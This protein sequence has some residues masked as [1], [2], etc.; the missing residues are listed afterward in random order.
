MSSSIELRRHLTDAEFKRRVLKSESWAA[1]C[2]LLPIPPFDEAGAF[3]EVTQRNAIRADSQLPLVDSAEEVGRLKAHYEGSTFADRIR[4][5]TNECVLEIYG[6]EMLKGLSG[7][8]SM[9]G[10]SASRENLIR[11]LI[12][13]QRRSALS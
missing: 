2:Q 7:V 10:F 4:H 9:W 3:A 6:A 13:D 11:A 5:L 1:Y 8:L 12:R